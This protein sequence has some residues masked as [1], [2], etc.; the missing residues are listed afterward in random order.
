MTYWNLLAL[1][2]IMQCGG[3]DWSHVHGLWMTFKPRLF[4]AFSPDGTHI[5]SG[6][7]DNT[8][9]LWDPVSG[10]HLNSLE[11]HSRSVK[12]V[13]FSPNGTLVV[14]GSWTE[15]LRIWNTATGAISIHSRDIPMVLTQLHSPQTVHVSCLDP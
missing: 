14:S 7:T 8:L 10:T 5:V 9:R 13:A 15:L 4:V 1:D 6:S 11:G 3:G 12:S 2:N